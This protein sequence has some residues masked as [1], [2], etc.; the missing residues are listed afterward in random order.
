MCPLSKDWR[1]VC[2]RFHYKQIRKSEQRPP[3]YLRTA[4]LVPQ[5]RTPLFRV[6][7]PRMSRQ[8]NTRQINMTTDKCRRRQV[9]EDN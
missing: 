9:S 8:I 6:R 3:L 5:S 2:G 1:S 4:D 7:T